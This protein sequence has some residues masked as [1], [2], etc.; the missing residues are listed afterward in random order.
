MTAATISDPA[1]EAGRD[2]VTLWLDQ[3][4][5]GLGGLA[6]DTDPVDDAARIDRITRAEQI[7]AALDAVQA[8]EIVA[9]AKSQVAE[10][11]RLDVDPRKVGRD[12]GDQIG[13]ACKVSPT[14][15]SRRLHVARDLVLDM[16]TTFGLLASGEI[17]GWTARLITGETSH[18]D[19][20]TRRQVDS[21]LGRTH[22]EE[23]SPKAAAAQAQRLAYAA[24]PHGAADRGRK[25]RKD[26]RVTLRPAPDT[27]SILSGLL[28]VEQGVACLAA[29][30]TEATRCKATGD[31]R[32]RSQIMAD[33]LVER[34]TGQAAATEIATEVHIVMPRGRA[35]LAQR[36]LRFA[37]ERA[38]QRRSRQRQ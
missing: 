2:E 36:R 33:T 21:D 5:A 16:P 12:I 15:G 19:P 34:I 13:L 4:L 23:K 32:S 14:E 8:N 30:Q 26:R 9:F 1:G 35:S 17:S 6:Y 29:L 3:I 24:D 20:P 37:T 25:A 18:L 10:Q 7:K 38:A 11:Q 22:L 28:P 27:M 31:D